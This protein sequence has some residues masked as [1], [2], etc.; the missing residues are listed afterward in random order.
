MRLLYR[1]VPLLAVVL[2]GCGQIE[3]SAEA[4]KRAF[5]AAAGK[6]QVVL[7]VPGMV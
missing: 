5:D 6:A 7:Q 1:S 4:K 3:P 2:V